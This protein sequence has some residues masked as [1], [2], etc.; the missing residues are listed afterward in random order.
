MR[1]EF[2]LHDATFDGIVIMEKVAT[3]YFR[4]TDGRGCEA[5]LSGIDALHMDDFQQGNIVVLFETT[6]GEPPR[7]TVGLERLYGSP[8]PSA[9][10]QYHEKS[11]AFLAR[12][13][14]A[15]EAGELTVVE[16]VPAIGADL[17]ATCERV[18]FNYHGHG[19]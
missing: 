5:R 14:R 1:E 12:K 16:M 17:L 2:P 8:H 7:K 3:L 10:K 11:E 9:A 15:I 4:A 18:E 6:T 13:H 19:S